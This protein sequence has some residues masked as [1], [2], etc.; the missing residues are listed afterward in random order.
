MN[1]SPV[2]AA[3]LVPTAKAAPNNPLAWAVAPLPTAMAMLNGVLEQSA[4]FPI[5]KKDA[6][7]A[8]AVG[9]DPSAAP[10]S[11]PVAATPAARTP[12][13]APRDFADEYMMLP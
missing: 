1:A 12:V 5:P 8:F 4:L 3:E 2:V 10:A 6:Q 11:S 13:T 9:A 7:L